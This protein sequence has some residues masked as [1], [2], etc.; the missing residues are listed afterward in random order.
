MSAAVVERT[1]GATLKPFVLSRI[2]QEADVF[3]DEHGAYLGLPR[4]QTVKH[5]VGEYVNGQA[6]TNGIESFWSMLKRGYYGTYH[7]MSPK[8]LQRYADEFSGRHNVRSRDT[9][10]QMRRIV[11]GL[12]GRRLRYDELIA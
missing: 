12:V 1:D 10:E 9:S 3:T 7:R 5:S 11:R 2:A 6:R 8:H 4:H